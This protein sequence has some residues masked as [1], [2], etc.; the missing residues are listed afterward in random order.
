[1][2]PD[3]ALLEIFHFCVDDHERTSEW[4]ALVHVCRKW[5][6][7]VF[8][9]PRRLNLRLLCRESTPVKKTID[10]WLLLP[11]LVLGDHHE[12]WVVDNIIA[13]LEHNDRIRKLDLHYFP[14]VQMERVIAAMQQPFTALEYLRLY[15]ISEI[16]VVPASFLSGSAPQLQELFLAS[17]PF[18]GLPKLLLSATHL[19]SL[20]LVLIPHS[21]YFSPEAMATGLSA[22]TGLKSLIIKFESP[23]SRPDRRRRPPL[24]TRTLFPALTRFEFK[25]VSEYLDDLVARIDAPLLNNFHITFFHQLIFDTPQLAQF[26]SRTPKFN[27]KAC[28]HVLAEFSHQDVR[29]STISTT[30]WALILKISCR[31]LDWQ[32]SSLAQVCGSIFVPAI[33]HLYIREDLHYSPFRQDD[34]ETGQWLEL[35]HRLTAVKDLRISPEFTPRIVPTLQELVGGRAIE[36]LPALQTLFVEE[37]LPSGVQETIDKF[38]AARELAGHPVAISRWEDSDS[39]SD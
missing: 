15:S 7:V 13:A 30:D 34:I 39:N 23:R 24:L 32:L 18:P 10:A 35:L 38:V 5:R 29:I 33:E 31:Q 21:G 1:M 36:V 6:N 27:L 2:L 25:G 22:L 20:H 17:I 26:I 19:V 9:S 16:E 11:I 12:T 28:N 14:R 8:G 4:Y 3:V 37:T